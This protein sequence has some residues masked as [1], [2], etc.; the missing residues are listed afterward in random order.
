[1]NRRTASPESPVGVAIV[2]AGYWGPNLLRNFAKCSG[3]DVRWLCDLDTDRARA[4]VGRY[5]TIGVTGDYQQVLDDPTVEAVVIAT[6]AGTH[7]PLG[8]AAL[9]AGKH[10]L[11]EKPLAANLTDG[12][13][14][15][16][17][18]EDR[19]L[20]LM[21]DHTYCYTPVVREIRSLVADG[22]LGDIQYI[23]SVRIN[24]GLIRPDADVIWD[25][26]PHDLSI[27][28]FVL[29]GNLRPSGVSA[30]GVDPVGAGHACVGYLSLPFGH[31]ALAHLHVNWL[32]PTKVRT[33]IIGGSQ[34]MAVWDDL[35]P[36]Q[37]LSLYDTGVDLT[38]VGSPAADERQYQLKVAYRAGDIVAPALPETEA[39]Y[40]V[41]VE[42][43]SAIKEGRPAATDGHAGLRVLEVLEASRA[44]LDAN[45]A[46]IALASSSSSSSERNVA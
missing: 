33:M 41:A 25:L 43:V 10:V 42:L 4:V 2:G 38:A 5:S 11:V 36:A 7:A 32:S 13:R 22:V 3:A 12:R 24:L 31:D 20:V 46:M 9:D 15:V 6:P 1:V 35:Q 45:G 30:Y 18:A 26:A 21:T 17:R 40:N 39:L 23:D 37:R 8:I 16:E 27:L 34:K 28:D 44:S 29:P 19:G 14:L